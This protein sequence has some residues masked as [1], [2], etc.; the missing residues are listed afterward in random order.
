MSTLAAAIAEIDNAMPGLSNDDMLQQLRSRTVTR[1]GLA[2]GAEISGIMLQCGLLSLIQ[3]QINATGEHTALRNMSIALK[4]R[5]LPDGQVD[6]G[7]PANGAVL[8]AF[9]SNATVAAM[10]SAQNINPH[11]VKSAI[12]G[13]GTLIE[14]E[15]PTVRMCDVVEA[16][17]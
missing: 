12:M 3:D 4:D 16:R 1:L 15:F 9:L 10:L 14:P 11:F 8:D 5:F 2:S 6:M 17:A 13:L 7:T